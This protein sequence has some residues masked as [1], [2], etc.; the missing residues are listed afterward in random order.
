MRTALF[1]IG[2]LVLMSAS[3]TAAAGTAHQSRKF[4]CASNGLVIAHR[5]GVTLVKDFDGNL[6]MEA[7]LGTLR[8]TH[9]CTRQPWTPPRRWDNPYPW[10]LTFPY[11]SVTCHFP[12]D[13]V[14]WMLSR[15]GENILAFGCSGKVGG[16]DYR[17]DF[18]AP[19][20]GVYFNESMI[21]RCSGRIGNAPPP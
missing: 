10:R 16:A 18:Y 4:V 5:P 21:N 3:K 13:L 9:G 15:K 19:N 17:G 8:V 1:V 20:A 6:L 11:K 14:V 12:G 7:K 2:L